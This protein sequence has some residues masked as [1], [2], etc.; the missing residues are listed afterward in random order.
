MNQDA[1]NGFQAK[2]KRRIA[3]KQQ[4][5]QGIE[6]V[7]VML[8]LS[9]EAN[10]KLSVHAAMMNLDRSALVEQLIRDGLKRFVVS[11]RGGGTA[12]K[13]GA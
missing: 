2:Q 6:K 5:R 8:H 9:V 1:Q 10:Q 4:N 7:R 3:V 13:S 11:D 12:P